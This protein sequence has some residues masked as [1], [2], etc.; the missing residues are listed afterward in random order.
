MS[1][2]DGRQLTAL[3]FTNILSNAMAPIVICNMKIIIIINVQ[4]KSYS[5]G[6]YLTSI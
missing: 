1:V 2:D 6:M 5:S 3:L 4:L